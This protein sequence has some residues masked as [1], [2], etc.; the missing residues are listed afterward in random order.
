M[1]KI[2]YI[3]AVL[4]VW[5]GSDKCDSAHVFYDLNIYS[6]WSETCGRPPFSIMVQS[7]PSLSQ[8]MPMV[9]KSKRLLKVGSQLFCPKENI[10][11]PQWD[12][13]HRH[14]ADRGG[15]ARIPGRPDQN[16]AQ[17][18]WEWLNQCWRGPK[19]NGIIRK[20]PPGLDQI[21]KVWPV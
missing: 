16:P 20:Q 4:W 21:C 11:T 14:G 18:L 10:E 5:G 9:Y 19:Y 15:E 13:E 17:H 6:N 1:T 3:T 7:V 8:M 2:S 12:S